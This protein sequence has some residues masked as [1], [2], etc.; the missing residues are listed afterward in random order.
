MPGY[1]T[2]HTF[3]RETMRNKTF[4]ALVELMEQ[5]PDK[6]WTK[7]ELSKATGFSDVGIY[8]SLNNSPKI[9]RKTSSGKYMQP[10]Y[11]GLQPDYRDHIRPD[12][13]FNRV[14]I[15]PPDTL[16]IGLEPEVTIGEINEGWTGVLNGD[17][18][19]S[20]ADWLKFLENIELA[21]RYIRENIRSRDTD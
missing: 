1:T 4:H 11:Y 17:N 5:N 14:P 19:S 15:V 10:D 9:F 20:L 12:I 6:E 18:A 3:E 13:T 16:L 8:K 7:K 2:A 21:V